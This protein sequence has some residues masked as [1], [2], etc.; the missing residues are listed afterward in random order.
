MNKRYTTR[1]NGGFTN[2]TIVELEG[3]LEEFAQKLPEFKRNVLVS[4][5]NKLSGFETLREENRT[6]KI[7]VG[8]GETVYLITNFGTILDMKI[9]YVYAG[10]KKMRIFC[11]NDR[12]GWKANFKNNAINKTVF[13]TYELAEKALRENPY[14][15]GE[16]LTPIE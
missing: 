11:K 15:E 14:I 1:R 13:P 12:L 10:D 4:A 16:K 5:I 8:L 3:E 6:I 9:I 7:P 2:A